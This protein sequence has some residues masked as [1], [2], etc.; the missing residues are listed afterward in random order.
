M[1][2]SD[3]QL[4][5]MVL[6]AIEDTGYYDSLWGEQGGKEAREEKGYYNGYAD[7]LLSMYDVDDDFAFSEEAKNAYNAGVDKYENEED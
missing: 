2:Y 3:E 1:K 6:L 4:K 7:A 5:F